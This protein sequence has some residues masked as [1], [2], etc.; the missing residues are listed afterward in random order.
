MNKHRP[1]YLKAQTMMEYIL[2]MVVVVVIVF[3]AFKNNGG[4]VLERTHNKTAEYF[5]TG[6]RAIMGGYFDGT[7]F[8]SVNPSKIDGGWCQW[9]S[10]IDGFQARECA[11]PRPAFGGTACVDVAIRRGDCSAG[12]PP[13][14]PPDC[15]FWYCH[16]GTWSGP[17]D[18]CDEAPCPDGIETGVMYNQEEVC[19]PSQPYGHCETHP[20]GGGD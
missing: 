1:L 4:G 19:L 11:C 9:S 2:V 3:L 12:P 7:T 17:R 14:P 20:S 6:T 8:T 13:P 18:A 10:C 5:N 15:H 16:L